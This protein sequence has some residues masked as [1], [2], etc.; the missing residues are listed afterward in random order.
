VFVCLVCALGLVVSCGSEAPHPGS[1]TI[2]S[3]PDGATITLNGQLTEEL[4]PA[5]FKDIEGGHY[6][7]QVAKEGLTFRPGTKETDVPYGGETS[8]FF[9]TGTGAITVTSNYDGASIFLDGVDTG[10]TTP[11]TLTELDPGDYAVS[12]ALDHHRSDPTAASVT[13]VKNETA[14]AEFSL[15]VSTVV[16]FEGFSNVECSGCVDMAASVEYLTGDGGYGP[17]R[18]LYIKYSGT[19]PYPGDPFYNS[20][21][22]MNLQRLIH[23]FNTPGVGLPKIVIQGALAGGSGEL[24]TTDALADAIDAGNLAPVDFY[25]TVDAPDQSDLAQRDVDCSIEVVA[26]HAAAD[27]ADYQLRAVLL[28]T[29]V[30]TEEDYGYGGDEY[31][32]VA[33]TDA[34]VTAS[35]GAI[36]AG[37]STTFDITL[38]DPDPAAYDLTPENRVVVVFVQNN[39]DKSIIQAGSSSIDSHAPTPG[40]PAFPSG[41][42][43]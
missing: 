24:P 37:G 36:E 39:T 13:V 43:R 41:G 25:L 18:F 5:T 29:F 15:A 1:L 34:Q 8:L 31:H 4:T 23:Y 32:W 33:R 35:I 11:A 12:V 27:L 17:D 16:L 7:V 22:F 14:N 42:S 40:S 30:T 6:V 28:Y 26:P 38:T 2:T 10:E 21:S 3:E 19:N 20:N 9:E